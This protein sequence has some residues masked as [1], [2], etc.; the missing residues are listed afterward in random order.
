MLF[1]RRFEISRLQ[2]MVMD[3][4]LI[5]QAANVVIGENLYELKFRVEGASDAAKPQPMDMDPFHDEG[6]HESRDEEKGGQHPHKPATGGKAGGVASRLSIRWARRPS[7][8][9]GN[10]WLLSSLKC[11]RF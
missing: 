4:N 3:P 9:Q 7:R 11:T 6:G 1:L 2:V 5:P 8:V 10:S